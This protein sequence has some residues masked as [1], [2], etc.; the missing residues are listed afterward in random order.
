MG[1]LTSQTLRTPPLQALKLS[2]ITTHSALP[3]KSRQQRNSNLH[4]PFSSSSISVAPCKILP[5][6]FTQLNVLC[7]RRGE[8]FPK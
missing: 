8:R 4:L 5:L 7:L 1:K 3:L 2:Q 6:R